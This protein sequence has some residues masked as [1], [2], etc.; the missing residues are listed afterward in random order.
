MIRAILLA[1]LVLLAAPVAQAQ[2]QNPSFNLVNKS[3][4]PVRELFVTPA[5]DANWGKSRL[6][7]GPILPGGSFA[8]RRRI[9]GNC[10]FDIRVVFANGQREERR[11]VNTCTTA[12]IIVAGA[13][14]AD[15]KP[16]SGKASDDPSFRLT[17]HLTQAIVEITT[18]PVDGARGANLLD[19]GPLVPNATLLMHPPRGQGCMFELRL[20]MADKTSKSRKLDLCKATDLSVP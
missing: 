5:G 20:V 6:T 15:A 1:V 11:E 2:E 3:G 16:A 10:V 7:A 8:V 9:D 17:N 14:A 12:D 18:T 4:Q 19:K 13:P